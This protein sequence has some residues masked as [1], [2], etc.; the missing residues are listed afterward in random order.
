MDIATAGTVTGN[1]L[2]RR[3]H[4]TARNLPAP[5]PSRRGKAGDEG[6]VAHPRLWR[7]NPAERGHALL[8]GEPS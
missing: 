5:R 8:A 6:I 4:A 1:A 2:R 7:G 3:T